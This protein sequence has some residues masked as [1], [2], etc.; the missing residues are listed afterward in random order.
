MATFS[1]VSGVIGSLFAV[2]RIPS[3]PNSFRMIEPPEGWVAPALSAARLRF[4]FETGRSSGWRYR[5]TPSRANLVGCQVRRCLT[6]DPLA[7]DNS[8]NFLSRQCFVLK[9]TLG[10]RMQLIEMRS[11][12]FPRAL[13]ALVDD[14][15]D[16]FVDNLCRRIGNILSLSD[17]VAEEHLFFVLAITQWSELFAKAK[18]GDHPAR[19]IGR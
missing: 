3:V 8:P 16:L 17:R 4:R 2:P 13:L 1:A 14:P 9:Q 12:D 5:A 18:L 15:A 11:Q 19:Q 10:K 6:H 7:P